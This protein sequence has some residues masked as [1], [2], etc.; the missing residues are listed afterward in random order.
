MIHLPTAGGTSTVAPAYSGV[1]ASLAA[2]SERRAHDPRSGSPAGRRAAFATGLRRDTARRARGTLADDARPRCRGIGLRTGLFARLATGEPTEARDAIA[3]CEAPTPPSRVRVRSR[4]PRLAR[5]RV[6]PPGAVRPREAGLVRGLL[7]A[8][9]RGR[10]LHL[11]GPLRPPGA[12]VLAFTVSRSAGPGAAQRVDRQLAA[13]A[14][15][16]PRSRCGRGSLPTACC[17]R[18]PTTCSTTGPCPPRTSTR[19]ASAS[20]RGGWQRAGA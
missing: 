19:S 7:A 3:A 13:A 6:R 16:R 15:S 2:G 8:A 12:C 4:P 11:V 18:S 10:L 17:T 5:G 9:A 14:A 20:A 1:V